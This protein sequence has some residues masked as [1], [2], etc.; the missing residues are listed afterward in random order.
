MRLSVSN[1]AWDVEEDDAVAEV[2]RD[3][4]VDQVDLAP[5]KYFPD[6][7]AARMSPWCSSH[8]EGGR[9]RTTLPAGRRA[10]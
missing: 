6:P 10:S 3:L 4:G 5:G 1:I 9:K 8:N 7:A 2:L